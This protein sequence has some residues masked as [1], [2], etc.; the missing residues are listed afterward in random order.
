[1]L[2]DAYA[3][4]SDA[5]ASFMP[6]NRV[7]TDPLRTLAYGTDASFYRLIPKLVLKVESEAEVTRVLQ[8]A[9]AYG[10]P[11]TFRA[12][13]TSVSGQAISDSV[14]LM[15][16]DGW[17]DFEVNADGTQIRLQPGVIGGRANRALRITSYN[18]CYTKLLRFSNQ[19]TSSGIA[20][21]SPL[22]GRPSVRK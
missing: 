20:V 2:S 12:A 13:G 15:L 9:H 22:V 21:I 3:N 5:L 7:I 18:V 8:L 10:T 1:M 19:E 14:L 17:Q 6:A 4:L 11:I 16:G